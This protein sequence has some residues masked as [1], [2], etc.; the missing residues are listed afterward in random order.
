MHVELLR[1]VPA[2]IRDT[3]DRAR[4]I[5][6]VPTTGFNV[7]RFGK[8]GG[9]VSLLWY[10]RFFDEAF[11]VLERSWSIDLSA[12]RV[13]EK[14][15]LGRPNPPILHRKETLLPDDHGRRPEYEALTLQLE[16]FGVFR[17]A[18]TIGTRLAWDQR[19]REHG[20]EVLGHAIVSSPAAVAMVAHPIASEVQRHRTAIHR[21]R[22]S[23]PM[24]VLSDHGYLEL[25]RTVLDYG[26]GRGDDVRLLRE[27]GVRV[28]GWDPHFAP[29][30]PLGDADVVNLGFVVNGECQSSCRFLLNP[31]ESARASAPAMVS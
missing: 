24:Q 16:S 27:R 29:A 1:D 13:H 4:A 2:C 31:Y 3:L 11:P 6:G 7:V 9:D 20:V 14:S 25:D 28:T 22:L 21:T 23:S 19:L 30:E 26:C 8:S 18:R 15:F 10:P 5:A 12:C 17:N